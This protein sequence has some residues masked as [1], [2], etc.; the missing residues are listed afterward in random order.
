MSKIIT[1][2][3]RADDTASNCYYTAIAD[4]ADQWIPDATR[5]VSDI[6]ADFK[7]YH[8][9]SGQAERTDAEHVYEMLVLGV[10]LRE[11]GGEA[12]QLPRSIGWLMRRMIA[13]SGRHPRLEPT[14][15]WLR[16]WLGWLGRKGEYGIRRHGR[17]TMRL[18]E[19]M[20]A[21]GQASRADR[22]QEWQD[23]LQQQ[24]KPIA[25]VTLARIQTLTDEF[26]R[27]SRRVLGKYT[28]GVEWFR[29]HTATQ[30][31]HRYDAEMVARTPLEYHM[32]M[33]GT[34]LLNRVNRERFAATKR[35]VVILPPCMRAQPDEQCKAIATPLGAQCQH[36]TSTCQ[37]H[38]ISLTGKQRGFDVFMIPDQMA[39]VSSESGKVAGGIGLVGVSCALTNWSGGWDTDALSLPAQGVLLD[40]VGCKYHWDE[41]G[42]PTA[43][44]AEKLIEVALAGLS[45]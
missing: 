43:V 27:L 14:F 17:D 39:R 40:F 26:D 19:W 36:C 42:I 13:L 2:S 31:A 38:L 16:G 4:L 23:Y 3:L 30:F 8:R 32:G 33:L 41:Q 5:M 29:A 21:Y 15:K 10:M 20:R 45:R 6:V 28:T 1:Y 34:E 24:S 12:N 44:N 9:A 7:A 18:L 11:H 22:L 25:Q 37:V 35:R